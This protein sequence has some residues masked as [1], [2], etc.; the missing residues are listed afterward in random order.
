MDG[1]SIEVINKENKNELLEK[2]SVEK[3]EII[4]ED[5]VKVKLSKVFK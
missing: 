3:I 4:D 1:N 2:N 5:Y